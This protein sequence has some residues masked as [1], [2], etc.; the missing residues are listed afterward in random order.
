MPPTN[1]S[2]LIHL[3]MVEDKGL[4]IIASRSTWMALPP[5]QI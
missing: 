3:K 2:E 4:K 1:N 5:Y